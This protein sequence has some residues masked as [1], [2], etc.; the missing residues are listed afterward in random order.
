[1]SRVL[2]YNKSPDG[3][4]SLQVV[5]SVNSRPQPPP[6]K[7][8]KTHVIFSNPFDFAEDLHAKVGDAHG[9]IESSGGEVITS[10]MTCACTPKFINRLFF[11]TTIAPIVMTGMRA[12]DL[13]EA[14]VKHLIKKMLYDKAGEY[15][16]DFGK[17]KDKREFMDKFESVGRKLK[18]FATAL[19][20][21]GNIE[22][23]FRGTVGG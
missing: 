22:R 23:A 12:P 19:S 5:W 7:V 2:N 3:Y 16:F 9:K 14:T 10:N 8:F 13:A 4:A 6:Q 15:F 20:A 18:I 17:S 1:M 21:T 11:L